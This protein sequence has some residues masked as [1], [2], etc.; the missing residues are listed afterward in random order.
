M[1]PAWQGAF[2]KFNL[3]LRAYRCPRSTI[4]GTKPLIFVRLDLALLIDVSLQS[5]PTGSIY[6]ESVSDRLRIGLS[7]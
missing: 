5:H 7:M 3:I 1:D 6:P 2:E 4:S